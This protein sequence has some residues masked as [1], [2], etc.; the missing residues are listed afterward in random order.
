M[1]TTLHAIC[2]AACLCGAAANSWAQTAK[3]APRLDIRDV[4]YLTCSEAWERSGRSSEQVIVMIKSMAGYSLARRNATFPDTQEAGAA[5]GTLI[6]DRCAANPD[7]SLLSIVDRS[8][9]DH[10]KKP[11]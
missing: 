3:P 7:E 11:N 9:R 1:N 10:V 8:I 4:A 5:V 2:L 6:K